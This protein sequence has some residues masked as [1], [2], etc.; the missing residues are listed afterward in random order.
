MAATTTLDPVGL[1]FAA[2]VI[3]ADIQFRA[4]AAAPIAS[5]SDTPNS[6]R[7]LRLNIAATLM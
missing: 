2:A 5:S 7:P 1:D 3:C 6:T 4:S